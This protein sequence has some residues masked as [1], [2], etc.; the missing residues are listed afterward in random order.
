MPVCWVVMGRLLR[1]VA[2]TTVWNRLL[3]S[4]SHIGYIAYSRV[5]FDL[6]I[7]CITTAVMSTIVVIIIMKKKPYSWI[8]YTH[9]LVG[10]TGDGLNNW[11]AVTFQIW[12]TV[13][14]WILVMWSLLSR[15]I[16]PFELTEVVVWLYIKK[17][18]VCF[19]PNKC[20]WNCL[21][22]VAVKNSY[23]LYL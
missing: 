10:E 3:Y 8:S 7:I 6:G 23:N 20:R 19:K 4:Y 17:A 13:V 9:T 15:P 18:I 1:R 22:S 21:N 16:F 2:Y 12:P 5:H 14:E 11:L